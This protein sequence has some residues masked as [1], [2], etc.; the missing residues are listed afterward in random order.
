[1]RQPNNLKEYC[2][3]IIRYVGSGYNAFKIVRI[4][5]NK[6]HRTNEILLK[7]SEHYKTNLSRGMRHK[8]RLKNIANYGAIYFKNTI[9]ILRTA[10]E[11]TDKENEFIPIGKKMEIILSEWVGLILH[12]DERE[13]WT[14]RLSAETF[15]RFRGDYF[16]AYKNKDGRKFHTLEKMWAG[17]PFYH[18]IGKQRIV[19]FEYFREWK[20]TYKC[21]WNTKK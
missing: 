4:D 21:D 1:M 18:G 12:K 11:H 3:D 2:K 6:A 20:K 8:G 19:L 14:F 7:V 16:L 13:I 17:F 15:S 5:E 9:I 10:G